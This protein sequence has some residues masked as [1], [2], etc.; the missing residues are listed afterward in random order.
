M[1]QS[2]HLV[3]NTEIRQ[4]PSFSAPATQICS[5]RVNFKS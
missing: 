2:G 5:S 3:P 1:A 4:T